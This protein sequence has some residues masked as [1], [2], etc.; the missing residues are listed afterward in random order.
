MPEQTSIRGRNFRSFVPVRLLSRESDRGNNDSGRRR[1]RFL[2]CRV[3]IDAF[4]SHTGTL[5]WASACG[6]WRPLLGVAMV[7]WFSADGSGQSPRVAPRDSAIAAVKAQAELMRASADAGLQNAKTF[8]EFAK[9]VGVLSESLQK[10]S[11]LE[12]KEFRTYWQKKRERLSI[13]R[14]MLEQRIENRRLGE[15]RR[16][17]K[18]AFRWES[19]YNNP[20]SWR[21]AE[22]NGN[23]LNLMLD[24]LAV[25]SSLAY[26]AEITAGGPL[27]NAEQFRL[28]TPLIEAIRVRVPSAR[29][30]TASVKL[31]E[32]LPIDLSWCPTLLRDEAFDRERDAISDLR[33][34]LAGAALRGEPLSLRQLEEMEEKLAALTSAFFRKY[35]PN[36]RKGLDTKRYQL[37]FQAEDFLRQL[38]LNL[39]QIAINGSPNA[40]GG[41]PFRVERDGQDLAS[42]CHFMLANSLRFD[43]PNPTDERHYR[44]LTGM[45]K[46]LC[47]LIEISPD[48]EWIEAAQIDL[49]LSLG[50]S[51]PKVKPFRDEG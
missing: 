36:G 24:Q 42:L 22:L 9:G 13:D 32:P 20:R 37:I 49:D 8:T 35:P 51:V 26:S 17:A 50:D 6:W 4:R 11:D 15:V 10:K 19:L 12:M 23:A 16:R 33:G 7:V 29:G 39:M 46:A 14:S 34:M 3:A 28:S 1:T 40:L 38:D 44:T 18:E 21:I 48:K 41:E 5:A 31:T 47:E 2:P 30:G 45:T 27:P 43:P 25:H